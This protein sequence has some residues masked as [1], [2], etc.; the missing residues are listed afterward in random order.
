MAS[1]STRY[2]LKALKG[3]RSIIKIRT[4]KDLPPSILYPTKNDVVARETIEKALDNL[5]ESRET[6]VLKFKQDIQV[7]GL[8]NFDDK[9]ILDESSV[10][11]D[12][13]ALKRAN[14][15]EVSFYIDFWQ[16]NF[17]KD[18]VEGTG[19]QVREKYVQAFH[20]LDPRLQRLMKQY[21]TKEQL[22]RHLDSLQLDWTLKD[23]LKLIADPEAYTKAIGKDLDAVTEEALRKR[24]RVNWRERFHQ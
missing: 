10:F 1:A 4:I 15:V 8:P 22:N 6:T 9:I 21:N 5:L 3:L 23:Y 13:E 11:S 20:N 24:R 16:V 12:V 7:N 19:A 17:W 14:E 18:P 2:A